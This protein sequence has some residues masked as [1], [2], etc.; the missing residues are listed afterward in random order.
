MILGSA[1]YVAVLANAGD[2]KAD[3]RDGRG[4][5]EVGLVAAL[6]GANDDN[7]EDGGRGPLRG[8]QEVQ[9]RTIRV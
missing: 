9:L 7:D 8:V 3:G 2:T 6:D 1:V 4:D 5:E